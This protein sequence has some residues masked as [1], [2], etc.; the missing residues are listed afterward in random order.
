ME[1][2]LIL[3]L[4]KIFIFFLGYFIQFIDKEMWTQKY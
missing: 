2:E 4:R 1:V 3:I